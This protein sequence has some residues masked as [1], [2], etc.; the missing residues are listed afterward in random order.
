MPRLQVPRYFCMPDNKGAMA[1]PPWGNTAY[2]LE[3]LRL[4]GHRL[5]S[6]EWDALP[7]EHMVL[8]GAVYA[9]TMRHPVD[10]WFS[11][12]RFEH[13]EKR[14]GSKGDHKFGE[15]Y[16][17]STPYNM[18]HNYYVKTFCGA[19]NPPESV[20]RKDLNRFGKVRHTADLYWSY[21]KFN[22]WGTGVPWADF[23]A[24]MEAVLR[25]D[26]L[27]ILEWLDY[28]DE[29]LEDVLGWHEGP[30]VVLPHEK[31]HKRANKAS[32]KSRDAMTASDWALTS[33]SNAFDILMYNFAK[34]VFLERYACSST[35]KAAA[36]AEPEAAAAAG[37]S[38]G[39]GGSGGDGGLSAGAAAGG[40][41]AAAGGG[42][43]RGPP[44][45]PPGGL[46]W[47]PGLGGPGG[48]AAGAAVAAARGP[49]ERRTAAAKP[50]AG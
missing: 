18:G 15:W 22:F 36:D 20:L 43:M 50:G 16:R 7:A 35:P 27:L 30:R 45:R 5:T 9:T 26:V 1:T 38:D 42:E 32:V 17:R 44:G 25:I 46:G 41:P 40:G 34:R 13:L 29:M 14:D 11:Q 28:S 6:N 33:S 48:P 23:K 3:Q 10:R 39:S 31:Q 2:L 21:H 49:P 24:A 8:P 19:E 12:Y 47:W 37:G 4:K